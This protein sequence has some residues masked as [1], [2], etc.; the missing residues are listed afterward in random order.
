MQDGRIANN[1]AFATSMSDAYAAG[2]GVYVITGSFAMSGGEISG[3]SAA[4]ASQKV[5]AFGGGVLTQGV[6][7]KTGG[8][9]RGSDADTENQN[10][11]SMNGQIQNNRGAAV[12]MF[13]QGRREPRE[14][15]AGK[16]AN[17]HSGK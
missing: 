1:R 6:F 16:D 7:A 17:I 10:T 3:N 8:I 4:A 15:T 13:I 14:T 9:I 12:Y 5:D 2:G 11:V